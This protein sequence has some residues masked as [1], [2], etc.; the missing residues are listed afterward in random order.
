MATIGAMTAS[1]LPPSGWRQQALLHWRMT[2]P[3]FLLV[4]VSAALVGIASAASCGCG[5]DLPAA[6]ATVLLACVAHAGA[7]VLN[8]YHDAR[9]GAD[10]ANTEGLYPFTGGSRLIQQGQVSEADTRRWAAMLLLLLIPAGLLLAARNGGGGLLL[11]GAAGLLIAWA[12][13]APPLKLMSR[14]LGELAIA[15]AWWLVVIGADYVQR[16]QFFLIP[17][18]LGFSV[19]TLVACVLLITACPTRPP[20]R[21]WASARW[22]CAWARAGRRR[23]ICGWC[24]WR[25][26]GW[27]SACGC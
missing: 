12:Y 15:A 8:D 6:L 21:A 20:I 9:N 3:A 23:C 4:T 27:R 13:S 5:F 26:A 22:P 24:C 17:A 2:R 25:T 18:S 19:A 7:N 14:G 16:G 10:A 1:T 11:V